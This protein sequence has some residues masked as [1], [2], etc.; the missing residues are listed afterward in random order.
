[1][2]MLAPAGTRSATA[3]TLGKVK[4]ARLNR[5]QFRTLVSEDADFALHIMTILANRL[6][7]SNSFIAR[8]FT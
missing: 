2:A 6:I 3:K 7:V 1:M 4:L 8:H 5:D